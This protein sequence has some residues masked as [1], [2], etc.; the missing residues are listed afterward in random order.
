MEGVKENLL[1]IPRPQPI[2]RINTKKDHI[3][4]FEW[5]DLNIIGYVAEKNIRAEM[6]V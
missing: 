5:D 2:V 3:C 6:A 4:E 1:R